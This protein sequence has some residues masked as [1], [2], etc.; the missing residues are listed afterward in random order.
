MRL[1]VYAPDTLDGTGAIASVTAP[2]LQARAHRAGAKI[3]SRQTRASTAAVVPSALMLRQ[4]SPNRATILSRNDWQSTPIGAVLS[5]VSGRQGRSEILPRRLDRRGGASVV[6]GPPRTE[7]R[8]SMSKSAKKRPAMSCPAPVPAAN[9]ARH[10]ADPKAN[11]PD[12]RSK[13]SRVIAM[14]QSLRAQRLPR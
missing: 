6:R 13:Q 2:M 9:A 7:R 4:T 3:A 11:K 14:L 12:T 5:S 8:I 1:E 10:T